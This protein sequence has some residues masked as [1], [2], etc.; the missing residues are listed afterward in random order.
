MPAA[1][2]SR[3]GH[4]AAARTGRGYRS[5]GPTPR[6]VMTLGTI[7]T[8]LAAAGGYPVFVPFWAALLIAT[9]LVE[10]PTLTGDKRD[11][12][13]TPANTAE[14]NRYAR[15]LA[16]RVLRTS[17]IFPGVAFKTGG[18][19]LALVSGIL[20]ATMAWLLPVAGVGALLRTPGMPTVPVVPDAWVMPLRVMNTYAALVLALLVPSV[21]A[22][23]KRP[24]ESAPVPSIG[25]VLALARLGP[26]WAS[27]VIAT[28][29]APTAIGIVAL[30]IA[31]SSLPEPLAAFWCPRPLVTGAALGAFVGVSCLAAMVASRE[32]SQW[33]AQREAADRW[34]DVFEDKQLAKIGAP[35]LVD[36][37]RHEQYGLVVDTFDANGS[38]IGHIIKQRGTIQRL[39]GDGLA[40]CVILNCPEL[41]GQGRPKDASRSLTRFR[42]V[43][44]PDGAPLPDLSDPTVPAD[45]A[46]LATEAIFAMT[47]ES[48]GAHTLVLVEDFAP[49]TTP[50][51][52]EA[53]A[54]DPAEPDPLMKPPSA[55]HEAP[56]WTQ[57]WKAHA[58]DASQLGLLEQA[59]TY[60]PV[61]GFGD[62]ELLALRDGSFVIGAV[63][64]ETTP[65]ADSTL[66]KRI[67]DEALIADWHRRWADTVA[68]ARIRD[69]AKP[70][71]AEVRLIKRYRVQGPDAAR[72]VTMTVT[73]FQMMRGVT[74]SQF[75]TGL[76]ERT[77]STAFDGA[78]FVH[79]HYWKQHGGRDGERMMNVLSVAITDKPV[80]TSPQRIYEAASP[81]PQDAREV[82]RILLSKG[83]SD[84]FDQ[85][86]LA[87]PELVEARCLTGPA[88]GSN[89][90]Q[91]QLRLVE[92]DLDRVR[93]KLAT[94]REALGA[95]WVVATTTDI[96][97]SRLQNGIFL[98]AGADP[99]SPLVEFDSP[100]LERHVPGQ[101]PRRGLLARDLGQAVPAVTELGQRHRA[102]CESIMWEDV[103]SSIRGL[104]GSNG[105]TPMLTETHALASNDSIQVSSF[106]LP[107]GVTVNMVRENTERLRSGTGN[108]FIQVD[109]GTVPSQFIIQSAKDDPLPAITSFDFTTYRPGS[110]EIPFATGIDGRPVTFDT[111]HD[112]HLLVLG[113]SGSGKT[114]ALMAIIEGLLGTGFDVV[115]ADPVKSGADFQFAAPWFQAITGEVHEASALLDWV[116]QQVT[117]RKTLN[118]AHGASSID[119]LPEGIRPRR[120]AVL[121]DE[122]T[123]LMIADDVPKTDGTE[124]PEL[125]RE[126]E[127][128]RRL[129]AA[130]K[131]IGLKTGRIAREARSA[132]VHL[133]L[134][135]Q[136]LKKDTLDR[137]PGGADLKAQLAR[138]VLGKNSFGSLMSALKSAQD[139]PDLG[140]AEGQK[141]RGVFESARPGPMQIVQTWWGVPDGTSP[142]TVKQALTRQL[143]MMCPPAREQLDLAGLAAQARREKAVFGDTIEVPVTAANSSEI[144]E[145]TFH[146]PELNAA[147]DDEP[148]QADD[149]AEPAR[150]SRP[151]LFLGVDQTVTFEA[152]PLEWADAEI[153]HAPRGPIWVSRSML[154]R[155]GTS[156]ADIVWL[157]DR[158]RDTAD[159]MLTTMLGDGVAHVR[160]APQADPVAGGWWKL[161]AMQRDLAEHPTAGAVIWCDD[162]LAAHV[163]EARDV[164][165]GSGV[166][167][168]APVHGLSPEDIARIEAICAGNA[169]EGPGDCPPTQPPGQETGG[170]MLA[171]APTLPADLFAPPPEPTTPAIPEGLFD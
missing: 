123:S 139:A 138:L 104:T 21:A 20:F 147:F 118:A 94:I 167:G 83:V 162:E 9:F 157:T 36:H 163:D 11:G 140:A 96:D 3:S 63:H 130:K 81:N 131:N 65:L 87:R 76:V 100:A 78:P 135:T 71:D 52:E 46:L 48:V 115:L 119:E 33:L 79:C 109:P 39:L 154:E 58:F 90:W 37:L 77:L 143:E 102:Y 155:L 145:V 40:L 166:V 122:F 2:R 16:A 67:E 62:I 60:A 159:E 120:L 73:P 12:F 136:E 169:P 156:G 8:V 23:L 95:P 10:H 35:R 22:L 108:A 99:R 41:D 82:A 112:P 113:P 152:M 151:R 59:G 171:P 165:A 15:F 57:A 107:P 14:K 34:G 56:E 30:P 93:S 53:L 92:A 148:E 126:I 103:F 38:D 26:G 27:G 70:H 101:S 18:I 43:T 141:G 153:V 134:A 121:I 68:Q 146:G 158:A 19:P 17:L 150:T 128:L 50:P 75:M 28:V 42:I 49:A 69:G 164:L 149:A 24:G 7:I 160:T 6:S 127:E 47:A 4:R 61:M 133:F 111:A 85:A 66:L 86:K 45:I 72:G 55:D 88:T 170:S 106:A 13:E 144:I 29:L 80:P 124:P 89:I 105:A 31:A 116:Y 114:A 110:T 142:P 91:L 132:G 54:D 74:L 161:T 64:A 117:E 25:G 129:A 137:I 5:A 1:A 32:V 168:I 84:A 51:G 97:G 98:V 125:L 44:A